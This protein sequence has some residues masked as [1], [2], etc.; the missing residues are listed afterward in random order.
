MRMLRRRQSGPC[1]EGRSP[2]G[3]PR[4]RQRCAGAVSDARCRNM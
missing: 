1:R 3:D 4:R 2:V